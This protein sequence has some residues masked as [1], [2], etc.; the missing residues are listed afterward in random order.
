MGHVRLEGGGA[1]VCLSVGMCVLCPFPSVQLVL[2]GASVL[3]LL[4][5]GLGLLGLGPGLLLGF[6]Q[7]P[8]FFPWHK[9]YIQINNHIIM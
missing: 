3:G 5:L 1:A 2:L 4:G 8:N 9:P 7:P 6:F